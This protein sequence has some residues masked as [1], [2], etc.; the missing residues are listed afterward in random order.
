[1]RRSCAARYSFRGLL[2]RTKGEYS[3]EVNQADAL[4]RIEIVPVVRSLGVAGKRLA[5]G[6]QVGGDGGLCVRL[7]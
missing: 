4:W 6:L 1:M 7:S 3:R 5:S 2:G